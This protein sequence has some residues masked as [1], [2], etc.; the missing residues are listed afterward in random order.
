MIKDTFDKKF[1]SPWHVVVGQ[2]F[3]FDVTS[4]VGQSNSEHRFQSRDAS[5][6]HSPSVPVHTL[7]SAL[8]HVWQCCLLW[9]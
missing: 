8:V 6:T 1:G 7:L 3:S 9:G 4:E 5:V 2:D